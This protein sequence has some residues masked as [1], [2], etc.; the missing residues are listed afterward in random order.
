MIDCECKWE[1]SGV[2]LFVSFRDG[3]S[4]LI[5]GKDDLFAFCLDCGETIDTA[6]DIRQCPEE[7]WTVADPADSKIADKHV[8]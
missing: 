5:Q 7:Y 2:A 1:V 8:S 6:D 3:K 4:L